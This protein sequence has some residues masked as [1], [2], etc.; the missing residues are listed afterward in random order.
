MFTSIIKVVK[1]VKKGNGEILKMRCDY[2]DGLIKSL[3]SVEREKSSY[4]ASPVILNRKS[5]RLLV[6]SLREH[7]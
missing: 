6:E 2:E 7:A 5:K 4:C 1:N 3:K